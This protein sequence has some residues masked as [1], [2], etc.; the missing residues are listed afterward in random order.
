MHTTSGGRGR[1]AIHI[2]RREF[3][4]TLGGAVAAWPL[5]ARAQ[6]QPLPVIAFINGASAVVS[7]HYAAAFR[8][9][10]NGTGYIE[11]KNVTVEY[12]WLDGQWDRLP[13][14]LADLV[15]RRVAVIAPTGQHP[16][17]AAKAATATIPIIFG[18]AED[19]VNL[20]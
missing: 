19:P 3:V 14:L 18:V 13:A 2:Q 7:P 20:G 16:A 5:A 11:H 12:H 6:Q 1:M 4:V 17:L 8:Q 15:S 9:G 10:L